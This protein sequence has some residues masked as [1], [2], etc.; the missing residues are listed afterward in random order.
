[1]EKN[2]NTVQPAEEAQQAEEYAAEVAEF[3][4]DT[5]Q[6]F[7]S[8]DESIKTQ[9]RKGRKLMRINFA[10]SDANYDYVKIM[11]RLYDVNMTTFINRILDKERKANEQ[12]YIMAKNLQS[13]M[14]GSKK[15]FFA[16]DVK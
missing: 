6:H 13:K 3:L 8:L 2:K 5:E 12:Y 16:G 1:M 9:G 14:E 7:E 10:F 11:S 4:E 15:A